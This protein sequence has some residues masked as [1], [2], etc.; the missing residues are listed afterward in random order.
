MYCPRGVA[1]TPS[2]VG[3]AYL[4]TVGRLSL[5]FIHFI[6]PHYFSETESDQNKHDLTGLIIPAHPTDSSTQTGSFKN[7]LLG[8]SRRAG[9]SSSATP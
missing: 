8:S 2:G 7:F 1:R 3:D 4:G 5:I 9:I 6:A